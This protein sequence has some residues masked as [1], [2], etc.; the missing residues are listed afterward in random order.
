[1]YSESALRMPGQRQESRNACPEQLVVPLVRTAAVGAAS[2][3]L[4]APPTSARAI[5]HAASGNRP[6]DRPRSGPAKRVTRY[7]MHRGALVAEA[8]RQ[9]KLLL[10]QARGHRRR[11]FTTSG[12]AWII[13]DGRPGQGSTPSGS[14]T[15]QIRPAVG[16]PDR[17]MPE[18]GA[19]SQ[20][21]PAPDHRPDVSADSAMFPST[22]TSR[23]FSATGAFAVRRFT[24]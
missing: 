9:R 15:P 11:R 6:S 14:P 12:S 13:F 16:M 1:M 8:Q 3:P 19:F 24:F 5:G 2:T 4:R 23:R 22:F 17:D 10:A 20:K 7:G 18:V 21:I